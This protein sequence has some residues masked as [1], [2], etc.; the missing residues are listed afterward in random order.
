MRTDF[1]SDD[2][3]KLCMEAAFWRLEWGMAPLAQ[4]GVRTQSERRGIG[5]T[6]RNSKGVAGAQRLQHG[7]PVVLLHYLAMQAAQEDLK[8]CL[9]GDFGGFTAVVSVVSLYMSKVPG[10]NQCAGQG[11]SELP[12]LVLR[13]ASSPAAQAA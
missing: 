4:R 5:G 13:F 2:Q 12:P 1:A 6:L 3:K 7:W 11:S 10:T 9:V 8:A